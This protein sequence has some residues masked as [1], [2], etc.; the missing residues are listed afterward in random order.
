MAAA[1]IVAAVLCAPGVE[2]ASAQSPMGS[3]MS[4][5]AMATIEM[6]NIPTI[7]LQAMPG[8]GVAPLVVGFLVSFP[9]PTVQFESWRWNFGDGQVSTL[10]P[11][12]LFHTY[13]NPGNYVVTLSATTSDGMIATAQAGVIVRPATAQ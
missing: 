2:R 5:G 3:Q 1:L 6:P 10:P 9:D 12:M 8:Y 13:K 7:A 4:P 11:L